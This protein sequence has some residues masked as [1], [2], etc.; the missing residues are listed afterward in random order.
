MF[1]RKLSLFFLA[2]SCISADV[3]VDQSKRVVAIIGDKTKSPTKI[4]YGDVLKYILQ[5]LQTR[6]VQPAQFLELAEKEPKIFEELFS[7][8]KETMVKDAILSFIAK[9]KN[10]DENP[11]YSGE[12]AQAKDIVRISIY[13]REQAKGAE[14]SDKEIADEYQVFLRELK[15]IK[16]YYGRMIVVKTKVKADSVVKALENRDKAKSI[17]D[18]FV[19]FEKEHSVV[20]FE[21]SGFSVNEN[22]AIRTYGKDVAEALNSVKVGSVAVAQFGQ[23]SKLSGN[24]GIFL[25]SKSENAKKPTAKEAELLL[26]SRLVA[27][28]MDEQ[29]VKAAKEIGVKRY[30]KDGLL[31]EDAKS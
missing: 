28:K 30:N 3:A 24:Y 6:G 17:D 8:I 9:K 14:F 2:L 23:N 31:E 19:S 27:K 5:M 7:S 11:A 22:E 13:K 15:D 1:L 16:Q 21:N 12:F 10:Y 26:K 18:A 4:T 29:I 25:V 20:P